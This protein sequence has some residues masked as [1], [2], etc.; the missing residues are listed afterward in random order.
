MGEAVAPGCGASSCAWTSPSS[1]CPGGPGPPGAAGPRGRHGNDPAAGGLA[2]V[3]RRRRVGRPAAPARRGARRPPPRDYEAARIEAGVPR[4][5]AELD[6]R[7]IPAEAGVVERAEHGVGVVA[8]ALDDP[9]DHQPAALDALDARRR[10][11]VARGRVMFQDAAE[12]A[13]RSPAARSSS[14]SS[15]GRWA[16]RSTTSS[17]L[18]RQLVITALALRHGERV[19]AAVRAGSRRLAPGARNRGADVLLSRDEAEIAPPAR[20]ET[21]RPAR[22]PPRRAANARGGLEDITND[23]GHVWRSSWL[24][25]R[26]SRGSRLTAARRVRSD[27]TPTGTRS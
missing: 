11:R 24:A 6:E 25:V 7:T 16:G 2:R 8:P 23:P 5:G 3:A 27:F 19:R 9:D 1:P 12:H 13:A 26:T 17:I 14:P 4:M 10:R 20:V 21:A 18:A 22:G 15:T